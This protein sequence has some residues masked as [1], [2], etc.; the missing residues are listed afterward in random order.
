MKNFGESAAAKKSARIASAPYYHFHI[1][2][3]FVFIGA[4]QVRP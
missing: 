1:D 3:H 2:E 4:P